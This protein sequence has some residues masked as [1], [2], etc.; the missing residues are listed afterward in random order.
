SRRHFLELCALTTTGL[1]LS[2]ACAPQA[3]A[4]KPAEAPKPAAEAP[5]PTAA[6]AVPTIAAPVAPQAQSPAASPSP[7]AAAAPSPAAGPAPAQKPAAVAASKG[8][9]TVIQQL[10][11]TTLDATMEQS[12]AI[13]NPAIHMD[14]P[15]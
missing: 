10:P 8:D 15:L 1:A 9:V 12:L 3:P 13:L 4:A 2:A 5:K 6:A 7:V 14:D 11:I